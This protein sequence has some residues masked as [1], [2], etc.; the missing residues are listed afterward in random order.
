MELVF[1][2]L[3]GAFL[4]N[5][6][7]HIVSGVMGNKHMTPLAKDSSALVNVVWGFIN[8]VAGAFIFNMSGGDLNR[9]FSFDNYSLSFMAGAFV[10][11]LTAAWMFSNTDRKWFPWF[12]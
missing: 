8:L 7:P 11:A 1:A 9:V 3:A 12:K 4:T 5:S 6:V 10:L 2:F